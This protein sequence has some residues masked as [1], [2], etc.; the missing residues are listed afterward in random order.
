M[1]IIHFIKLINRVLSLGKIL[2]S[3]Q[4]HEIKIFMLAKKKLNGL[5][6]RKREKKTN[7]NRQRKIVKT[8]SRICV[9]V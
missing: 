2:L 8:L 5:T 4:Q 3:I 9:W 6:Q 1:K 7:Y